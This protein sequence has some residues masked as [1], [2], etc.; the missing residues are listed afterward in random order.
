MPISRT[1]RFLCFLLLIGCTFA[2][3]DNQHQHFARPAA[4]EPDIGFW[5][6]V[7]TEISSNEGFIHDDRY[8]NIV[9][10]RVQFEPGITRKK[11]NKIVKK[12]KKH[13]KSTLLSLARGDH[14]NLNEEERRI[15]A[16]WPENVER[17]T[18]RQAAKRLRFQLGQS[19]R[20]KEGLV[21]SGRWMPHILETLQS[22]D[23]PLEIS[24]LP[25]V[26]S[27]F[28]PS[29][30]SFVGAA[31][32]WQ[33]TRSTGR[34]FMRI[35]HIVDERLDPYISSVAAARL[36]KHN[37]A[38]TDSWPLAITAYNHGVSGMRRAAAKF[39]NTEIVKILREY[40]SRTF[41]FASRNFYVAFLAAVQVNR[42]SGHYYG[43]VTLDSPDG[44]QLIKLENYIPATALSGALSIEM[45]ILRRL[46]PALR[47][48]VWRG[49]KYVP[50][51]YELRVPKE[52]GA[53]AGTL[54]ASIPTVQRHN[55]QLPDLTYRVR[56]GDSLSQIADRFKVRVRDLMAM[57]NL[58]NRH[59]IRV[60]QVL[61]LPQNSRTRQTQPR[62]L[63]DGRYQVRRG[64]T[65]SII[66]SAF[67]VSE[68][69]LMSANQLPNRNKISAGQLL[70]ITAAR[71]LAQ[72]PLVVASLDQAPTQ[73][74][75]TNNAGNEPTVP[76]TTKTTLTTATTAVDK[77]A[78]PEQ[79]T[80]QSPE[81]VAEP[82]IETDN[83]SAPAENPA[84]LTDNIID[85]IAERQALPANET[86]TN[87]ELSSAII[88]T[89]EEAEPTS[90]EEAEALAPAQPAGLHPALSADPSDYSV[91]DNHIIVQAAETLGH[92]AEW[93]ELRASNLRKIN[94]M[95]F[96]KPVIIGKRLKL[97]FSKVDAATFEQRRISYHRNL[98]ETYFSEYQITGT[99]K[100]TIRRGDSIWEL[101]HIKYEVPL[102]L[103]LQYN[104]DIR[105]NNLRPGTEIVLPRTERR[106]EAG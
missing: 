66:A 101:T 31:G 48:P 79:S 103:F 3:A 43:E 32:M 47:K 36:L 17:K 64:D 10:D 34:R 56:R 83:I 12:V 21:R 6:R 74:D 57:N 38:L 68:Q 37:Y 85:A 87:A 72:K 59:F 81:P 7:Y 58:S 27:S 22:M 67:S 70:D 75:G 9:Y 77:P 78:E 90:E 96:G 50:R 93:L 28:N 5:V 99:Y 104:P 73:T 82:T 26:E 40:K 55:R 94:R 52:A 23:L 49:E 89:L 106:Q 44:S 63:V 15:L 86:V 71:N 19:D 61:Q 1:S 88:D 97:D 62:R 102:W 46:N 42:N 45:D 25:H 2:Q 24:A 29:A 65:L 13:L 84:E 41:K 54:L 4:L 16:L 80:P 76:A 11:R 33:F 51:G 92:Y 8:L 60:G 69:A 20:F 100:H 98:Q 53:T 95:R 30:Y 18:L 35:D 91:S 39:G 105:L 14:S